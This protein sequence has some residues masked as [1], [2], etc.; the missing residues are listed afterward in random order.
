MTERPNLLLI[1]TDTQR[2]DT[3]NCM[4]SSFAHSPHADRLAA[5]GVMF[6]QGH[7]PSPVCNPSRSSLIT[8]LHTP[9][10]GVWENGMTRLTHFPTLPDLL[11]EQGYTNIMVGKQH[12]GQTPDTFD[13]IIGQDD[14]REYIPKHGFTPQDCHKQ[15]TP[16]PEE[17][18]LDTFFAIQTIEQIDQV[19]KSDS[20]PFFAF[21]SFPAPHPPECPPGDWL[22]FYDNCDNLPDL[23]YTHREEQNQPTHTKCLLGI[24]P[25]NECHPGEDPNTIGYWREAIGRIYDP[26]YRDT[27]MELRKIYYAYAAYCDALL[28]RILNYLDQNNLRENTLIIFTS[29]HGQ[30]FFDHGFND[31]HNF[32]DESWRVPFIMSMPG[33]LPQGETCDFA[34]WND[35]TTTLLAA[36]G[37]ECSS[38]QG[39]DLFTP[40]T[41]GEQSPRRC[42]VATLYKSCAV[43]TKRWKLSYFFEE[44]EGRL[45][46]RLNDPQEQNDLYNH[47]D[48]LEIR[49]EL[50]HALLSWR[51]DIADLK[52]ALEGTTKNRGPNAQEYTTVAPRIAPHTHQMRGTDAEQR[53]NEKCE[54]I[55]E[56]G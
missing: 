29:D 24:K 5:E 22:T 21:C 2:W 52:T 45:F 20:G 8:G 17:H 11:K 42:A 35:I 28:G 56:M 27:I 47:P 51:G 48:H 41:R 44:D 37:T 53:L 18:F 33:T 30:Q 4:G 14:Y 23:N 36:A 32:Y 15:P 55:D 10:H 1:T 7:T 19:V 26:Q 3:L 46:D 16:V 38:M 49:N 6:T 50:R 43:A 31:K 9:I 12:F 40:L 25:E 54:R 39:F 34:I 13:I